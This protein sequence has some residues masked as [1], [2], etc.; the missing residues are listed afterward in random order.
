MQV[1]TIIVF[2]FTAGY[3]LGSMGLVALLLGALLGI[4]VVKTC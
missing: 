3:W 2:S 4:F 1:L